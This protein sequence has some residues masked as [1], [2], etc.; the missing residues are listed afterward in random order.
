[1]PNGFGCGLGLLQLLLYTIYCRNKKGTSPAD[2][3]SSLEMGLANRIADADDDADADADTDK[4]RKDDK[5]EDCNLRV[6]NGRH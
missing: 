4:A 5:P 1:M 3:S 6:S 2:A